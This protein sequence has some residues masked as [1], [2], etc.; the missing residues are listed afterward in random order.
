MR[1]GKYKCV[2]QEKKSWFILALKSIC[3]AGSV[4]KRKVIDGEETL[5]RNGAL[6]KKYNNQ[7]GFSVF[8]FPGHCASALGGCLDKSG[9]GLN[10]AI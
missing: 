6:G 3:I 10:E 9:K 1:E 7:H 4:N 2:K 8:L 5:C